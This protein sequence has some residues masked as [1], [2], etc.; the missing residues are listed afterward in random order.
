[1]LFH[2]DVSDELIFDINKDLCNG[3]LVVIDDIPVYV[4][5]SNA[6]SSTPIGETR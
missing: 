6:Q 3:A 1:M 4:P 2:C 5:P